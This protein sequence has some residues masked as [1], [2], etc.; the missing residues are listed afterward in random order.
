[1][2]KSALLQS[3][4]LSSALLL[5]SMAQAQQSMGSTPANLQA[6]ASARCLS[7]QF[8]AGRAAFRE[9]VNTWLDASDAGSPVLD[10]N[11]RFAVATACRDADDSDACV[12]DQGS[13]LAEKPPVNLT[14]LELEAAQAI[15]QRCLAGI[16]TDAGSYRQCL[17]DESGLAG[18]QS[19]EANSVDTAMADDAAD[20]GP[21]T[22]GEPIGARAATD[23][24]GSGERALDELVEGTFDDALPDAVTSTAFDDAGTAGSEPESAAVGKPGTETGPPTEGVAAAGAAES[25]GEN[26]PGYE[27]TL[28]AFDVRTPMQRLT[29]ALDE[30]GRYSQ[31]ALGVLVIVGGLMVLLLMYALMRKHESRPSK[32]AQA[33]RRGQAT[34]RR[35]ESGQA[36][37]SYDLDNLDGLED[38]DDLGDPDE[39]MFDSLDQSLDDM[40]EVKRERPRNFGKPPVPASNWQAAEP[41]SWQEDEPDFLAMARSE[42]YRSRQN[43]SDVDE[44]AITRLAGPP[45][46][47]TAPETATPAARVR[48]DTTFA[49]TARVRPDTTF[50]PTMRVEPETTFAPGTRA[51]PETT[52]A[53]GARVAPETTFAPGARAAPETTFAPGAR[54][55]PETTFAPTTRFTPAAPD[56]LDPPAANRGPTMAGFSRWLSAQPEAERRAI[57]T[58]FLVYWVAYSDERYDPA[59]KRRLASAAELGTV[60]RIKHWALGGDPAS[61]GAAVTWLSKNATRLQ[62]QQCVSLIMALLITE[63]S[64]TP[65]QTVMLR[66]LADAFDIGNESL[67]MEFEQNYAHPLPPIPRPDRLSWWNQQ[68]PQA[69]TRWS[70]IAGADDSTHARSRELFGLDDDIR[71]LDVI[72]AYR[73]AARRCH[74]DRFSALGPRERGLA[75]RQFDRFEEARDRLLGVLA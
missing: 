16:G 37:R 75:V 15:E 34:P 24:V 11:E 47:Y 25:P 39:A 41:S 20:N 10:F 49:P 31:L 43:M 51:A 35:Q 65:V 52:F 40:P 1:M 17:A 55:A 27:E 13:A 73:R 69:L 22:A 33:V 63:R 67:E 70:A 18:G 72:K 36:V 30:L 45:P 26:D 8:Q 58:E 59:L 62:L 50:A 6:E 38:L 32:K 23:D 2:R 28:E 44:S 19:A 12:R 57:C 14:A 54:A 64:V 29:D 46:E 60:D 3:L 48:P 5:S 68:S 53:P 74:P 66:L 7:L 21:S 42:R 61:L 56:A 4:S 71:D 9:C